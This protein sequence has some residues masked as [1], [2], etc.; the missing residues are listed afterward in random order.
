[1]QAGARDLS[2]QYLYDQMK[3]LDQ[4]PACG[5]WERVGAKVLQS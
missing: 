1:M 2:E 4:S 5:T 3:V